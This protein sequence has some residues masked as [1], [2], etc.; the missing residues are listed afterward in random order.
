VAASSVFS[1]T[2]EVRR[3][4]IVDGAWK[5]VRLFGVK[6]EVVNPSEWLCVAICRGKEFHASEPEAAVQ[7]ALDWALAQDG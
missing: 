5:R 2:G 7:Y 6:V 3:Y 4:R 1:G